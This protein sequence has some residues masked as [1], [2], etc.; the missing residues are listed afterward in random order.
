PDAVSRERIERT[1]DGGGP[2]DLAGVGHRSQAGGLGDGERRCVGLGW[3]PCLQAAEAE[4]DHPAL[5]ELDRPAG[6]IARLLAR[7]AAVDVWCEAHD[8]PVVL[9]GLLSAVA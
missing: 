1:P 8:D 9:L 7:S 6:N 4:A 5:L 3:V 2:G